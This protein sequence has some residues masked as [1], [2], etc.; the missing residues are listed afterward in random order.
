MI[1]IIP[2]IDPAYDGQNKESKYK[3]DNVGFGLLFL[4]IELGID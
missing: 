2:N 4:K 3:N 1:G